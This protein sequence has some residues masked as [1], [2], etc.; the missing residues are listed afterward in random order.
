MSMEQFHVPLPV[1][2]PECVTTAR[3]LI[4]ERRWGG[5]GTENVLVYI[6]SMT[7]SYREHKKVCWELSMYNDIEC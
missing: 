6:P 3:C 1:S 2:S 4:V 7:P 5:G